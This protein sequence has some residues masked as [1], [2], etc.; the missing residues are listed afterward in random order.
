MCAKS[1]R[2]RAAAG[3]VAFV[4][5]SGLAMGQGV[6]QAPATV[7]GSVSPQPSV[8]YRLIT[9]DTVHIKVFQEDDLETTARIDND[10]I[11]FFPLLGKAKIGGQTVPEATATMEKLLKHYL[12]NPQVSLEIVSYAK[13]HFTI[14][15]QV[16]KPGIFD[17]PDEGTLNLLEALGMAGG[18]TKIA[19]PHHVIIK[20]MQNGQEVIIPVDAKKLLEGKNSSQPFPQILPGDTISVAES[21][22]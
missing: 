9:K 18:Y 12:I 13:Q 2:R 6:P 3:V 11:I 10:G 1:I 16:N 5:C 22:F 21:I 15:G 14:L 8:G 4:A 19:D 7:A 17:M 20:R